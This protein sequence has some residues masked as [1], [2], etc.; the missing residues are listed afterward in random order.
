[1]SKLTKA[2]QRALHALHVRA[3][4]EQTSRNVLCL[5]RDLERRMLARGL[6]SK[7]AFSKGYIAATAAGRAA[8]DAVQ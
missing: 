6:I 7:R 3:W 4:S 1:M 8:F 5:R 2:E